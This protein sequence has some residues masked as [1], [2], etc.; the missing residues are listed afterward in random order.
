MVGNNRYCSCC[1]LAG[2]RLRFP[3]QLA[4]MI[5]HAQTICASEATG[6]RPGERN[7]EDGDATRTIRRKRNGHSAKAAKRERGRRSGG[8][9]GGERGVVQFW[10]TWTAGRSP[11]RTGKMTTAVVGPLPVSS[12]LSPLL[13]HLLWPAA[14]N[15][16]SN[17]A[18]RVSNLAGLAAPVRT[19]FVSLSS[20]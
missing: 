11:S 3:S 5:R 19:R 6:T 8:G 1:D 18:R 20:R 10:L 13:T 15:R 12:V 7:G 17:S 16:N 9:G 2:R 14:R 4:A